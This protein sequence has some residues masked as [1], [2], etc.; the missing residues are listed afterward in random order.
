MTLSD[1]VFDVLAAGVILVA[2]VWGVMFYKLLLEGN[3]HE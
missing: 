1:F 2:I 3:D